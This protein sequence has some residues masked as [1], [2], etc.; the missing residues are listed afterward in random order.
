MWQNAGR[1]DRSGDVR[2]FFAMGNEFEAPWQARNF[3]H[4]R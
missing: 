4:E 3:Q 1:C 2:A